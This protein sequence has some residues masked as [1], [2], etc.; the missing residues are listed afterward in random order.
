MTEAPT[1]VQMRVLIA[2]RGEIALR[3]IRGVHAAGGVAIAIHSDVDRHSPFVR[4]ADVSYPMPGSPTEAYLNVDAVLAACQAT[5][6]TAVHP[7]YGFLS[8][9]AGFAER[10][11]AAGLIFIG[12]T[13]DSIR[14]MGDKTR[15]VE[16]AREANVPTVPSFTPDAEVDLAT[17]R[18]EAETIGLPLLIKAAAGGG[19]KGMRVARS[20]DDL[21]EM[22]PSAVREA[23]N[24]FGD[25]RVFLERYLEN[26]KHIEVQV[27]GDGHGDGVALGERDCSV[28]RR[29]QKII[30][31]SPAPNLPDETRQRLHA[32]ALSLV[33]KTNYRGAGTVE[34]ILAADGEFFFLEMNTRLQVEHPVTEMVHGVDLV[35]LQLRIAHGEKIP[36]SAKEA[37]PRGHAIEIR[38]YAETPPTFMPSIGSLHEVVWPEGPGVRV[39]SGVERGGEVSVHYDPMLAKIIVHAANRSSA[40]ERMRRALAE[41]FIAGVDTTLGFCRDVIGHETFRGGHAYTTLIADEFTDWVAPARDDWVEAAA[42]LAPRLAGAGSEATPDAGQPGV[43]TTLDQWRMA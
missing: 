4:A 35:D 24:A 32:A 7:G 15:A 33:E 8:E 38:V 16:C 28:Q 23:Q 34:F 12:P 13:A 10:L 14:L 3:V 42:R 21:A 6:A 9:N 36:A 41:T 40:I 20:L 31:E 43:W 27:V 29:H 39:D 22:I 17:M 18:T 30:E 19:G 37:S 1:P 2:N 26:A 25:G 11:E 5:G